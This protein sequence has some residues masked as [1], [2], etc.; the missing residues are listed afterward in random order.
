MDVTASWMG[1]QATIRYL[2][3]QRMLRIPHSLD[4]QVFFLTGGCHLGCVMYLP[5]F[6]ATHLVLN[7]EK[8]NFMVKEKIVLGH[9]VTAHGIE[10]DKA[11]VDRIARLPPPTSVKS[12][13]NFLGHAGFYRRFIKNF[14]SI[15]KLLTALLVKNVK[16]VFTVE[17]LRA[18][19][20]I[21]KK[22][23]SAP[24][25]VTPD[26]SQPFRIVCDSSDVVVGQVLGQRKNKMFR[27]IY[28][29]SRT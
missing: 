18:F 10:V 27:P 4:R 3:P 5:L 1:T 16:V 24:I 13:R 14:S 23:V 26:W 12:I 29:A 6:R 20:L 25:M 22:L 8:C 2:L 28:C 7:W 21:K 11:K 9:K 15:T 19:E 17:S